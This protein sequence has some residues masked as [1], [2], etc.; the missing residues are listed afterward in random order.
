MLTVF[1][2]KIETTVGAPRVIFKFII[3]YVRIQNDKIQ[4]FKK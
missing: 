4:L 3:M 2:K 1:E